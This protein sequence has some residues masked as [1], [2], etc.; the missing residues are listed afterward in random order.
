MSATAWVSLLLLCAATGVNS[1]SVSTSNAN[2]EPRENE[3]ADL[4]CTYS[5]DFGSSPRIEWKFQNNKGSQTYVV[6]NGVPTTPYANRASLFRGSSLRLSKVTRQDNGRYDC[7]VS[8]PGS[9]N[10]GEVSVTLTVLVPP[11]TPVCRVPSSGTTGKTVRLSCYDS[12]GSPP[13]TY[14]WYKDGTPLPQDPSQ[15]A[16][17]KNL[18][19]KLDPAKGELVFPAA[20]KL[21]SGSYH[22]EAINKAGPPQSCRPTRLEI[23]DPNVGGIV[24]GVIVGLLLLGVLAFGIWYA[25][26]KG[27]LPQRADSSKQKS[28]VVYQPP[29]SLYSGGDEDDGDFKQKSSFVV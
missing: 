8:E 16:A 1:F 18:T 2:V 9:S 24:A 4:T 6:F 13:P 19:Y 21:D 3:D 28:N 20:Q 17:F 12:N 25:Y 27:Y 29:S 14:K 5:G 15:M 11:S 7:E 26:K 10:F 23:R 22:C